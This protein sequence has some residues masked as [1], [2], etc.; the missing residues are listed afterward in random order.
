MRTV[1]PFLLLLNFAVPAAAAPPE[2]VT[3]TTEHPAA[4]FARL[5]G[6]IFSECRIGAPVEPAL[7]RLRQLGFREGDTLRVEGSRVYIAVSL[8]GMI[9]AV[10]LLDAQQ[11]LKSIAVEESPRRP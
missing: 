1:A 7:R 11:R 8:P 9:D 4:I 6:E 10:L 5:T 3:T 2:P